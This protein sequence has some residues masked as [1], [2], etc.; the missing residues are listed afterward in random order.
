MRFLAWLARWAAIVAVTAALLVLGL[1]FL[2]TPQ[3]DAECITT[4]A[5]RAITLFAPPNSYVCTRLHRWFGF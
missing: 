5:V 1:R 2:L 4:N 3:Y